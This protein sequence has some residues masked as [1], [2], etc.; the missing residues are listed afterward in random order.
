M[1]TFF[2][3]HRNVA[4]RQ[5]DRLLYS[6]CSNRPYLMHCVHVMWPKI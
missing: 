5:T 2:A 6:T 3:D 1:N 4:N